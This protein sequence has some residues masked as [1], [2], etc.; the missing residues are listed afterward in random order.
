MQQTINKKVGLAQ[1]P[2]FPFQFNLPGG[3]MAQT[4]LT[5]RHL[6]AMHIMAQKVGARS[7]S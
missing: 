6:A 1:Y 7:Y 4:V 2:A 5:F 3:H